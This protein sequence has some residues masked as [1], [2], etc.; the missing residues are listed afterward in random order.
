MSENKQIISGIDIGTTK[1]AVVIAEWNK[2]F[3]HFLPRVESRKSMQPRRPA[4]H[5]LSL[6]FASQYQYRAE[7]LLTM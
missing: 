1:I 7:G 5:I 2:I 6:W 4:C 3:Q